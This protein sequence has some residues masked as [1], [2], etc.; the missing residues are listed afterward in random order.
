MSG[1][2]RQSI[3]TREEWRIR[4]GDGVGDHSELGKQKSVSSSGESQAEIDA[5]AIYL[6]S[7][8]VGSGTAWD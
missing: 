8:G 6:C 7:R 2:A 5:L 3:H 1:L 4:S